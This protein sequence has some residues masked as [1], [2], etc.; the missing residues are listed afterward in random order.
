MKYYFVLAL[1]LSLALVGFTQ[2]A[3]PQLQPLSEYDKTMLSQLPELQLSEQALRRTLPAVVDNSETIYFRPLIAQVGLE[4]G[5]ASSIGN[6][7]TYEINRIRNLDGSL[8][9]NQYPTHFAYNFINNGS[10]AG[11]NY[12]ETFEILRQVGTPNVADYGGMSQGGPSRWISGYDAYYNGMHNRIHQ[13]YSIKTSTEE[14]LQTLKNWIYDHGNGAVPGGMASFYAT[15]SYPPETL[16]EGTAEAGKHVIVE[17][18]NSA[19][20]AM[21]IVGYHDDIRWDYNNDG[22]YTND[23]DINM[24]GIVDIRDWEIGG[25]KMANTYGSISG[26]GDNGFSYMMYKSVADRFQQGGIWDN[27]VVV[28]DVKETHQPQIAAKVHL[29]HNCRNKIKVS[30][31]MSTD[32]QATEPEFIVDYPIFDFQGGCMPMQGNSGVA[33]IEF[34]LDMNAFLMH[35][36]PGQPAKFFLI[37]YEKDI[38]AQHD[39]AVNSFSLMDY[40][41]YPTEIQCL[42]SDVPI[43]NNGTTILSIDATVDFDPVVIE[44]ES[45]PAVVLYEAFEN[46][47]TASG[48]DA[49]YY[50]SLSYDY[51]QTLDDFTYPVLTNEVQLTPSNNNN[52]TVGFDLP[53][54]FPFYGKNYDE[55]FMSVDGFLRFE[56][57]LSPW[58]YY[59]DGRTYLKQ[60][61]LIA[62]ALSNPFYVV[63]ANGDGLW[64]DSKPDSVSFRWR[65]SV[66][67]QSGTSTVEMIASL[68]P[69]GAIKLFYG[70][71][72]AASYIDRYGGISA[73]D[74]EN[75]IDLNPV[76]AFI[77]TKD[78]R[79][80]FE[81][82]QKNIGVDLSE[83]GLLNLLLDEFVPELNIK[84]QAMDQNNVR[85]QKLLSFAVEGVRMDAIPISGGDQQIDFGE[86][87]ALDI[88]LQNLNPYNIS[89]GTLTLTTEDELFTIVDHTVSIE[90]L[91]SGEIKQLNEIFA[92]EVSH[93][94]PNGYQA[95]F[96]LSFSTAEDSW[97]RTLNFEVFNA[98][99]NP[100]YLIVNDGDNGILDPGDEAELIISIHN[101]GGAP[102][103]DLQA[104]LSCNNTDL[105][106][107][108]SDAATNY[109]GGNDSWEAMFTVELS[110]NA[111]PMEILELVLHI[112]SLEEY[113]TSISIPI[114]TSL[115]LEDFETA[116]FQ[117]F[118]WNFEGQGDWFIT[119]DVVYEG[120]YAARSGVIGDNNVSGLTL[121]YNVPYEDSISFYYKVSSESNYDF[122]RFRLNDQTLLNLSGE[123]DWTRAEFAVPEGDHI[124][125]WVYEKDYS[126][127]NGSD[128]VW[129][130]Y[131]VFPVR[132]VVTGFAEAALSDEY[133]IRLSPNPVRDRMSV[134]V[135]WP[136]EEVLQLLVIDK[137]GRQIFGKPIN[138]VQR[139]HFID[140]SSWS[141]GIY[142]VI[143]TGKSQ[144]LV[145]QMIRF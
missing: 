113:S 139:S 98:E 57:G 61:K 124:L 114:M 118:E 30:L 18:G 130:D 102:L 52:G 84:V 5:Q 76:G 16:P 85:A 133:N 112:T 106:I 15:F 92:V 105:L 94:I 74:G 28:V 142:T 20:H 79:Y 60:N 46:Q 27:R 93:E 144:Q 136:T 22:Q 14:G 72:L 125:S 48:G 134:V 104:V 9:E 21:T 25:F 4:C 50:W 145:K 56:A 108:Q 17:W 62:P 120:S 66:Y 87:F 43:V 35:L 37:V 116:S 8:P 117:L 122:F 101:S 71:H 96:L 78:K 29:N 107:T 89:A 131:I 135:D 33:G 42:E 1:M 59:I 111:I 49:P 75:F 99:L 2:E 138:T 6:M 53:F 119:D 44:E 126:M 68:F 55:V 26:W 127:S 58:P 86:T 110:E 80:T 64:V 47:L 129:L 39:G 65:L 10:D 38:L 40:T 32:M 73:G 69:D 34:G 11:V 141:S 91:V 95:V 19:N 90:A 41:S 140:V 121:A 24:D 23:I 82:E 128:C 81:N 7:F 132:K 115:I 137:N 97:V 88:T 109:L 67:G 31:G 63:P 13:V 54:S 143:L 123:H 103:H 83:Q 100:N 36:E 70:D 77:P 45:L 12:Y 3:M 51:Q